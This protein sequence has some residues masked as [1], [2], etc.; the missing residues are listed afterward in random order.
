MKDGDKVKCLK[1]LPK[2]RPFLTEGK[3]YTVLGVDEDF[4]FIDDFWIE[5]DDGA[6]LEVRYDRACEYGVW[7]WVET[8]KEF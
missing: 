3:I 6:V 2:G 7:N 1:V 8:T 5:A 4:P